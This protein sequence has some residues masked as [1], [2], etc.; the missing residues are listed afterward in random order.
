MTLFP[1]GR[2]GEG[3]AVMPFHSSFIA[4]AVHSNVPVLPICIQYEKFN[5]EPVTAANKNLII[6]YG[7]TPFLPHIANIFK[8]ERSMDVSIHVF[9]RMPTKEMSRKEISNAARELIM[10]KFKGY[11]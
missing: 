11:I 6:A 7:D 5:G 10:G 2:I 4:A 8:N 1:E 3:S 9:D